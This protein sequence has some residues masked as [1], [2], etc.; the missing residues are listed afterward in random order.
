MSDTPAAP[1]SFAPS[2]TADGWRLHLE[3][4]RKWSPI[5]LG[6]GFGF[7]AGASAFGILSVA[8]GAWFVAPFAVLFAGI[9]L[10]GPAVFGGTLR[11]IELH[12]PWISIG[13]TRRHLDEVD[14]VALIQVPKAYAIEIAWDDGTQ[15][16][17]YTTRQTRAD[18]QWLVDRLEEV[19]GDAQLSREEI[20][21]SERA[22]DHIEQMVKQDSPRS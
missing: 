5:G 2:E 18:M 7:L 11:S 20:D 16:T 22:K 10:F 12:H 1:A 14:K 15:T 3:D 8:T 19:A 21:A 9:G 6:F 13:G 4:G 17:V